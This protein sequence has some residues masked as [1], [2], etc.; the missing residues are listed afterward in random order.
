VQTIFPSHVSRS[1]LPERKLYRAG[2]NR[3]TWPNIL[4]ENPYEWPQA[5]PDFGPTLY[6]FR[7]R[8]RPPRWLPG[9][10]APTCEL[11]RAVEA[12]GKGHGAE[13][14]SSP[15]LTSSF[16]GTE[17]TGSNDKVAQGSASGHLVIIRRRLLYTST[18][19]RESLH[20]EVR[21]CPTACETRA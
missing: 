3:E 15:R 10:A 20:R 21:Q 16:D 1:L 11:P 12:A 9:L 5:G 2:P 14:G 7:S 17:V 13:R 6:Y 8:D 18:D 4:T 19:S